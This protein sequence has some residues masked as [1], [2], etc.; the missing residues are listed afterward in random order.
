V[1]LECG[2]LPARFFTSAA[3]VLLRSNICQLPSIVSRPLQ[4]FRATSNLVL[5]GRSVLMNVETALIM[6]ITPTRHTSELRGGFGFCYHLGSGSL[7]FLG[8]SSTVVHYGIKLVLC[9]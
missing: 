7:D 2:T 5:V 4:H 3:I 9:V 1:L 6:E 8:V